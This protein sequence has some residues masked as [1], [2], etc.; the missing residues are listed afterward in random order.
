MDYPPPQSLTIEVLPGSRPDI[1]IVKLSGPLTIHN[2]HEFQDLTRREPF[3]HIMLV[4][5]AE[6]PYLD[7][8][9]LG[10]FVGIHVSCEE[11]SRKYALVG[12]NQRLKALFDLSNVAAFLVI[13]GSVAEAEAQLG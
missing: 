13:Y 7:S 8:A 9:A 2:F 4:D 6:V 5:L 1:Q 10:T 11:N 12:A 3:P